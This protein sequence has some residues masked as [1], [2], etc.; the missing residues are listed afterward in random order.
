MKKLTLLLTSVVVL[1]T[2]MAFSGH[3]DRKHGEWSEKRIEKKLDKMTKELDLS[4]SQ[5]AEIEKIMTAHHEKMKAQHEQFRTDVNGVLNKEQQEKFEKH[6]KKKV[7][8]SKEKRKRKD[9]E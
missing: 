8:K 5:R 3:G 2:G 1:G 7:E 9:K 4:S 6:L